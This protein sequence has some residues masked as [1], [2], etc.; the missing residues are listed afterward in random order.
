[1]ELLLLVADGSALIIK[2]HLHSNMELLLQNY[3]LFEIIF[4]AEFTFQY[5]A[6]ST[7]GGV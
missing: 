1:M 6:T 4:V 5:G 7:S 3:L 2:F